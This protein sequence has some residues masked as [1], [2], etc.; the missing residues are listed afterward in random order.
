LAEACSGLVRT[1]SER[2][3]LPITRTTKDGQT[4]YERVAEI[5]AM[6]GIK[7]RTKSF[8]EKACADWAAFTASQ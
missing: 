3:G 1:V 4:A 6:R 5:L 8:V 2:E 7:G